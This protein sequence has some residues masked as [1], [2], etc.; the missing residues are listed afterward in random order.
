MLF[1]PELQAWHYF[2]ECFSSYS[3]HQPS[4]WRFLAIWI[5][6]FNSAC[7][8]ELE[9]DNDHLGH[10]LKMGRGFTRKRHWGYSK[11]YN[12]Q[13]VYRD[14]LVSLLLHYKLGADDWLYLVELA[15]PGQLTEYKGGGSEYERGRTSE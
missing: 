12:R 6:S 1:G 3:E 10:H 15:W 7:L 14:A 4:R 5:S 13:I 2:E 9:E 11:Q 8:P